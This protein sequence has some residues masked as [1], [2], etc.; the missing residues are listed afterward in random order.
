MNIAELYTKKFDRR[1]YNC[2]DFTVDAAKL[3]FNVELVKL[4]DPFT[5][6]YRLS[7]YNLRRTRGVPCH[8]V[9]VFS[10]GTVHHVG[11]A[12]QT[13][14]LHITELGVRL[15]SLTTVGLTFNRR[16]FYLWS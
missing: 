6:D 16:R 14:M 11:I 12:L 5:N 8:G 10:R 13:N 4:V 2:A 7:L 9:V 15:E 3:L 1:N